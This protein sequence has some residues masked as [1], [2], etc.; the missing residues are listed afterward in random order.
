MTDAGIVYLRRMEALQSLSLASDAV[1]DAGLA[2]LKGLS[3]LKSL[4]LRETHVRGPGLVHLK[5]LK[6]LKELN[7]SRTPFDGSGFVHLAGHPALSELSSVR[8]STFWMQNSYTCRSCRRL[9]IL[10][11]GYTPVGD[12]GMEHVK[13][14]SQVREL[15]LNWSRSNRHGTARPRKG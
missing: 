9:R 3:S 6:N 2:H 15:Y 14:L 1:S 10:A 7:L 5:D 12:A 8:V 13:K 11:L 4:D